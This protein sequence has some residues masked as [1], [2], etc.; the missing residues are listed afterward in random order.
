VSKKTK[1]HTDHKG[2]TESTIDEVNTISLIHEW[3]N[4][5]HNPLS[6]KERVS[7]G[8]KMREHK[9]RNEHAHWKAVRE[10]EE[11]LALLAR[12]DAS[13]VQSMIPLRYGRMME[14]PFAFFRGSAIVMANDLST[15]P[16]TDALVQLCGDCHLSNFGVFATAERNVIFDLNDFDETLPGPFEW[17]L[18]RLAASFV[19]AAKYNQFSASVGER[20]VRRIASI[21]RTKMAQF[22][23]MNTLDVWYERVDF[24]HLVRHLKK[25][26]RRQSAIEEVSR[27]KQKRSQAA[28]VLKL[29][30]VVNGRR[31]IKDNP[32]L[33]FHPEL[34]TAETTKTLLLSYMRSLWPS[35]QRLLERFHFVDVALKVVGVGSVGTL[36]W[37][38]LL[39][40][41]GGDDDHIFLQM[42][43]ANPSVLEPFLGRSRFEYAGARIVNGQRLLQAA[44]DMFL[45]WTVSDDM[46]NYYVRQ[47]RDVKASIPVEELDATTFEQYAEVCARVLARGHARTGDAAVIT[48][49]L[50]K[51]EAFDE[52]L[53]EFALSYA[54][55]NA[56]DYETLITAI[57]K[58]KIHVAPGL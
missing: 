56:Y 44:S 19:V 14:S 23:E 52:A 45:G 8:K 22:A 16:R 42:K 32:P 57:N 47:L 27:L 33:V 39:Q 12:Q 50:G 48:G 49:Y 2:H 4:M 20:C 38:I 17:D 5:L 3:E 9:P 10:R 41:E 43:E 36:G 24:E 37:A 34:A 13:R 30:E 18:K 21:Y 46:N 11:P 40:G 31:R 1:T 58:G 6:Y 29:T 53:T 35:R 28:S 51:G 15:I 7:L 25:P 26:G 55:Q 54:Q